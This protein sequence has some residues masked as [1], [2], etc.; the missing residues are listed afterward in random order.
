[1]QRR[2]DGA[3]AVQ[4]VA[5]TDVRTGARAPRRRIYQRGSACSREVCASRALTRRTDEKSQRARAMGDTAVFK[6]ACACRRG[7]KTSAGAPLPSS[8]SLGVLQCRA[9][10][11]GYET[12]RRDATPR[13]GSLD[14]S[15]T[16]GSRTRNMQS[17][18]P[19][20]P[21]HSQADRL[22]RPHAR[23]AA[24]QLATPSQR[25]ARQRSSSPPW[26]GTRKQPSPRPP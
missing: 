23:A 14:A 6:R 4:G 17:C 19:A 20:K 24:E 15:S 1:M 3:A 2:R 11:D 21:S 9:A 22:H 13:K 16:L 10:V 7:S 8:E 5:I 26:R 18:F 25:C 12:C